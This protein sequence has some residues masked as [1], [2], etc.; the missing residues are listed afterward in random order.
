[1]SF[2]T[3][4]VIC[5]MVGD[6]I[7]LISKM[8]D[9]LLYKFASEMRCPK[10]SEQKS[11]LSIRWGVRKGISGFFSRYSSLDTLSEAEVRALPA[12]Q[13]SIFKR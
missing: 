2:E 5:I 1:M 10:M 13:A 12:A 9:E 11:F 6:V 8:H 7:W 4:K 3:I